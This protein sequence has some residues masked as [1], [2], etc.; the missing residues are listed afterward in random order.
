VQTQKFVAVEQP[1]GNFAAFAS[2]PSCG[3]IFW[4]VLLCLQLFEHSPE[5]LSDPYD[6]LS[7]MSTAQRLAAGKK[8][9]LSVYQQQEVASLLALGVAFVE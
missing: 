7:P 2:R 4:H 5:W 8:I 9:P 6:H 3:A 1:A